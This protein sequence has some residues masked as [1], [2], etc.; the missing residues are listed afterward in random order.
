MHGIIEVTLP[1]KAPPRGLEKNTAETVKGTN[2]AAEAKRIAIDLI[3]VII[4]LMPISA[5]LPETTLR[6][7]TLA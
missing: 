1:P 3:R 4:P 6:V 7:A 2:R 5:N